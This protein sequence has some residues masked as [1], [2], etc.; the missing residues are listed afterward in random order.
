MR[1]LIINA[2]LPVES[3]FDP[4]ILQRML[5]AI[6][7]PGVGQKPGAYDFMVSVDAV[8]Y[9]P[10]DE[11]TERV[12]VYVSPDDEEP[13]YLVNE[14]KK[15]SDEG[16]PLSRDEMDD[17]YEQGVCVFANAEYPRSDRYGIPT[18]AAH[19]KIELAPAI[20]CFAVGE[21]FEADYEDSG[22]D[23]SDSFWFQIALPENHPLTLKAKELSND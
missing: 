20:H 1:K 7:G 22:D 13:L 21:D 11:L 9:K 19:D 23:S 16:I 18:W 15:R 4:A 8:D 14:P 5:A 12:W 3:D 10:T 6:A 17:L 2:N